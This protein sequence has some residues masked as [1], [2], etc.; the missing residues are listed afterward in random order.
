MTK[1]VL[2]ASLVAGALT[3]PVLVDAPATLAIKEISVRPADPV[4]GARGSVKLVIDVVAKGAARN[5][6]SVKV[7]PG[8]PP[9]PVPGRKP[10]DGGPTFGPVPEALPSPVTTPAPAGT[11][12]L[13]PSPSVALTPAVQA[14]SSVA[15]GRP[16]V[17][18]SSVASKRP[19]VAPSSVAS[20]RPAVAPSSVASKRP[21]VA[22]SSV[23]PGRP[24]VAPAPLVPGRPAGTPAAVAA[25]KP[26][27]PPAS[28]GRPAVQRPVA[29]EE[30]A[31]PGAPPQR[32]GDG[33]ETWRFMPS[34]GLT[35]FYPSGV[36]TITATAKAEDGSTV[37]KYHTF[38][39]RHETKLGDLE[40]D[41][42]HGAKA[43]RL[44]GT[45]RRVDP[46]G[47]ADFAPF[48]KQRLEISYRR[49]EA[50]EW[51]QVATVDTA[52]TGRFERRVDGKMH[53]LW[54]VH[55]AGNDSYAAEQAGT[56][57]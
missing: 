29:P 22:P 21:A 4:V 54:R 24:A 20:K 37:T 8:A 42:V 28:K 15:P 26:Q 57:H 51:Q 44:S 49:T 43:V 41:R 48:A 39:L 10:I 40:I 13:R 50:E 52:A 6:V 14:P 1:T 27:A 12:A 5:G 16:A 9:K 18:P 31:T 46:N 2:L 19:A 7:E 3:G 34:Q 30:L 36:W 35:R 45:L 55:Y 56:R 23:A 47:Y 32:V 17:A 25:V 38:N 11:P 33:W 53:G